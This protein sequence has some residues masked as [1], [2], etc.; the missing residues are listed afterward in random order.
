MEFTEKT[1]IPK[2][3]AG[4]KDCSWHN[5]ICP[6]YEKEWNDYIIDIW[7]NFDDKELRE[8][9]YQYTIGIREKEECEYLE[10]IDFSIE[11]FTEKALNEVSIR[12]KYYVY[13]LMKKYQ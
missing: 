5:D 2:L 10:S 8:I 7:I 3:P 1:T 9:E 4:F 11:D 12:M 13:K 6:H